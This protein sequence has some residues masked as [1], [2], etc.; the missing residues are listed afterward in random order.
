MSLLEFLKGLFNI[1]TPSGS[2]GDNPDLVAALE[3][4]TQLLLVLPDQLFVVLMAALV[5]RIFFE[6]VK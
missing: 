1:G 3:T 4:L 2:N 6:C 5:I